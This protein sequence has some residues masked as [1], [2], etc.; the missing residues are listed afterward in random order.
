M[1]IASTLYAVGRQIARYPA[2][3]A[4]LANIAVIMAANFG[5]H[6]TPGQLVAFVSVAAGL[7]GIIV[8]SNVSPLARVEKSAVFLAKTPEGKKLIAGG[9]A[10]LRAEAERLAKGGK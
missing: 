9:E 6:L 3:V 8:H 10:E 4:A 1:K 2:I 7:L 5:L